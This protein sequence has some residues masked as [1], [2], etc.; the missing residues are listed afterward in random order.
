MFSRVTRK[1]NNKKTENVHPL[2]RF[3]LFVAHDS[4]EPKKSEIADLHF[5]RQDFLVWDKECS[6]K[7][8][9]LWNCV[10]S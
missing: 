8:N 4:D 2:Q 5:V 1:D 3:R 10:A 7:K 6:Q 9:M